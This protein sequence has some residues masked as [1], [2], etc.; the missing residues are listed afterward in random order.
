M[1]LVGL[2]GNAASGKDTVAAI[3]EAHGMKHVSASDAVREELRRRGLEPSRELQTSVANELRVVRGADYFVRLAL[4]RAADPSDVGTVVS[5]IYA[6]GEVAYLRRLGGIVVGLT[7]CVGETT[8][9]RLRYD[10]L[11]SRADGSR[12]ALTFEEFT[13]AHARENGGSTDHEP[14][15]RA[16][17]AEA[18]RVVLTDTDA[19]G[20]HAA[21][22]EVFESWDIQHRRC[23]SRCT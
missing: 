18:D 4:E 22:V 10:R 21:V 3:F 9:V 6:P 13:A 1:V 11:A 5:G 7:V 15:V 12:D 8:D 14:N 20:L 19:T 23:A 2:V 16:L 17:L